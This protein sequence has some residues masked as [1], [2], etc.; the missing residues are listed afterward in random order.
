MS[1]MKKATARSNSINERNSYVFSEVVDS[2]KSAKEFMKM[3]G[4]KEAMIIV[5]WRELI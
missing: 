5:V 1:K 4:I 2:P 3:N